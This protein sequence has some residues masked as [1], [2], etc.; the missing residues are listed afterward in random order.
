MSRAPVATQR[1]PP[2][3]DKHHVRRCTT[4]R[5]A[6]ASGQSLTSPETRAERFTTSLP[7]RTFCKALW[8]LLA[9]TSNGMQ[10]ESSVGLCGPSMCLAEQQIRGETRSPTQGL[11]PTSLIHEQLLLFS[12]AEKLPAHTTPP[13][14]T[15]PLPEK[16]ARTR[17]SA[18]AL[19]AAGEGQRSLLDRRNPVSSASNKQRASSLYLRGPPYTEAPSARMP[20]WRRRMSGS[21]A[22]HKNPAEAPQ[23][24]RAASKAKSTA[25]TTVA[26]RRA[27]CTSSCRDSSQHCR[28][29]RLLPDLRQVEVLSKRSPLTDTLAQP[30]TCSQNLQRSTGLLNRRLVYQP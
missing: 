23:L 11:G 14:R 30:N 9:A 26:I 1:P 22:S 25:R 20:V 2:R 15:T 18:S 16:L 6:R 3:R 7:V 5:H 19:A 24:W 10:T 28:L 13:Q 4:L 12:G 17:I 27:A 21:L 8:H 29:M